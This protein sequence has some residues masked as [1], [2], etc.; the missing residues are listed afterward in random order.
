MSKREGIGAVAMWSGR[1]AVDF[2]SILAF[3]S[4]TQG[5][6]LPQ[7]VAWIVTPQEDS[8]H[9]RMSIESDAKHVKDLAFWP[10]STCPDISDA[11]NEKTGVF[12]DTTCVKRWVEPRSNGQRTI[13]RVTAKHPCHAESSGL[14]SGVV[15]E[16]C[17]RDVREQVVLALVIILKEVHDLMDIRGLNHKRCA[18][19]KFGGRE[20]LVREGSPDMAKR[21][22]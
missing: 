10:L 1:G 9:V 4:A 3:T 7:W 12:F 18:S 19:A 6:I 11:V 20:F 2:D 15:Q 13:M 22:M 16:V 17:S 8:S 5:V 21:W 14:R